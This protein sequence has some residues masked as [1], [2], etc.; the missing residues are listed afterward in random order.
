MI[1]IDKDK[2]IIPRTTWDILQESDY[3]QEI[4]E[5]IEDIE[6]YYSAKDDI[7]SYID[8]DEYRKSRVA[9]ENV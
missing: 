5:A 1:T 3:Y 7:T 9:K 6:S 8:Y 2:V 4:I